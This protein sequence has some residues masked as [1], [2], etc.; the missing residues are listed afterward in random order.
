ML[1]K[2]GREG[3]REEDVVKKKRER[4]VF[5]EIAQKIIKKRGKKLMG[6]TLFID[7]HPNYLFIDHL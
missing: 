4:E 7:P 6:Y 3:E 1:K 5:Q 2:E